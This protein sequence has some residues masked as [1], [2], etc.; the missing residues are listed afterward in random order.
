MATESQSKRIIFDDHPAWIPTILGWFLIILIVSFL[1]DSRTDLGEVF[2]IGHIMLLFALFGWARSRRARTALTD[3]TLIIKR[4]LF[5]T[6]TYE[7]PLNRIERVDVREPWFFRGSG[8]IWRFFDSY[9]TLDVYTHNRQAL[10]FR[11][12]N[13]RRVYDKAEKIGQR[14][15]KATD[16]DTEKK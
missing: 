11:A 9:G 3:D 12:E 6:S 2:L 5:I 4:G 7:I 16:S 1:F 15:I 10:P 13:V 14:L 8:P